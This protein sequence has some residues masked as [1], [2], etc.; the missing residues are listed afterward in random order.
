MAMR[1]IF[2]QRMFGCGVDPQT[3]NTQLAQLPMKDQLRLEGVAQRLWLTLRLRYDLPIYNNPYAS[4]YEEY[5]LTLIELP[6]I[7]IYLLVTCL[8]TLAGKPSYVD[9]SKWLDEQTIPDDLDRSKVKQIY[10]QYKEEYGVSKNLKNLF[11]RLPTV[12]KDWLANNVA[13][14][15]PGQ[16]MLTNEQ[17]R[18]QLIK[19]LFKYF[20][21]IRRNEFTRSSQPR[22][23]FVTDDIR[24]S[25]SI[26]GDWW[27]TPVSGHE[28][29]LDRS[30][31]KQRW[32]VSYR[33][34]IDEATI[35][36]VIIH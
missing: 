9:F 10:E 12:A 6:S 14:W 36:R 5:R 7:E 31:P 26:E 30:K 1:K 28:T 34:G 33:E 4:E 20:Y 8:D 3:F 22:H 11:Q 21:E 35:L 29:I 17:D 16:P 13:I 27:V 24:L 2:A 15:K 19:L 18:D 25:E 23:T 32:N